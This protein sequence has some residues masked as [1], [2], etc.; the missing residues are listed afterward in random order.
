M[1]GNTYGEDWLVVDTENDP[2]SSRNT[3]AFCRLDRPYM[4]IP[5]PRGGRPASFSSPPARSA[6]CWFSSRG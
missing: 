6:H 5:A 2:D 3:K 1:L 4:S